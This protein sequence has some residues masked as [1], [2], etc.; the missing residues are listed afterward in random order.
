M[1]SHYADRRQVLYQVIGDTREIHT[2]GVDYSILRVNPDCD[3][4]ILELTELGYVFHDRLFL[5]EIPI[6]STREKRHETAKRVLDFSLIVD[7]PLSD[8]IYALAQRAFPTDRR[9]HLDQLFHKEN[10][11]AI[12]QSYLAHYENMEII[13]L[14][15]RR[16]K[17]L[18][19][20]TLLHRV[21]EDTY[22]NVLGATKPGIAGKMIAWPLYNGMLNFIDSKG[23]LR[24]LG[25]V[26]AAN[27]ASITLHMQLGAKIRE[28]YDEY[29]CR[30]NLQ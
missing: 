7:E 20:F 18:L 3:K 13:T 30:F 23:G 22:E 25:R 16:E 2:D 21:T 17:E 28:I 19:G 11:D 10:A 12:I 5:M 26:S 27:A 9:F 1:Q 8:D 14:R 29:I 4:Q 6:A 24:Y 15:I